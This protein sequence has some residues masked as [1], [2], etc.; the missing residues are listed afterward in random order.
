MH[1]FSSSLIMEGNIVIAKG[2]YTDGVL[3][4]ENIDFPPVE[5]SASSRALFSDAN[6]FGGPHPTSLK[7]SEKF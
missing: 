4:V 2:I 5:S 3:E 1:V 6:T 7:M